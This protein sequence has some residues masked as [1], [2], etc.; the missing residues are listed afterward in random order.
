MLI[1]ASVLGLIFEKIN[2]YKD[3]SFYTPSFITMYMC[4]QTL[5]RAI[6]QKF[7]DA[8]R[9][10]QK[11]DFEKF[12]EFENFEAL[13]QFL[14]EDRSKETRL[15]N[16][17]IFDSIKIC[18]PAVGSGHFLVSALNELIAIK[19]DLRILADSEGNR[20]SVYTKIENDELVILENEE[21][22][23][24]YQVGNKY[25]QNIQKTIFHEKQK[26]IENCLFGVDI[27]SNSV[28]I[29]QLR[30]WI[31]L[32]KNAYYMDETNYQDLETFPNID[33]NIKVGDSLISKFNVDDKMNLFGNRLR[34][35]VK[36]R[37]PDFKKQTELYKSV[38]DRKAKYQIEKKLKE[39]RTWF[40]SLR[41]PEDK[42]YIEL[43]TLE[44]NFTTYGLS[45]FAEQTILDKML[46]DVKA[47]QKKYDKK[48]EIYDN[49]FEWRFEF[50]EVLDDAGNFVGFDAIIGN[51]PY[52]DIKALDKKTVIYL[53]ENYKTASNRIN[54]YSFFIERSLEIMTKNGTS[55]LI[56]PNS[57]LVNSSYSKIR[58]LI[59]DDL[60]LP[61]K[62]PDGVFEEA[63]VE[64]IIYSLQK[65]TNS[66]NCTLIKYQREEVL[67][68]INHSTRSTH[69]S[70]EQKNKAFWKQDENKRFNIYLSN[71]LQSI[72]SKLEKQN[73]K[74]A[75]MCDFSLGIT[76]YDKYKGH[77][78]EQ[79]QK[80]VF[81]STKKASKNYKPLIAGKNIQP[82]F[83]DEKT[84]E[85]IKY[86]DWLGAKR[87]ERF[88]TEDRVLVRQ[89]AS[90]K[91][92][93]IFAS[94][95]EKPL[96]FTQIA[97]ALICK[98][99]KYNSKIITAL[100]NSKLLNTIH[101]Y[102]YLD[103]EKEV[104]QKVLIANCKLLPIPEN[105][106][107][108]II[109]QLEQKVEQILAIKKENQTVSTTE[110]EN[111]ID[112]LVYSLYG[113]D[114]KEINVIEGGLI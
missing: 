103:I 33:I 53:F 80:K 76:P 78:E 34:D 84:S 112:K 19:E 35:L 114:E 42:E 69:S 81:H 97:F 2:G 90:S 45:P 58:E 36:K 72:F 47:A 29:C 28:K 61:I 3:G 92:P 71:D 52:I 104:F 41:S 13:Q 38:R 113:L 89:I 64:T 88:F 51:P 60:L 24:E 9:I 15:K 74:L 110:L 17:A 99:E 22:I 101:R 68:E 4:R 56:V 105:P 96:Y 12:R 6:V 102:L 91:P 25:S 67:E 85:Y 18:D 62:L 27:N 83:I 40:D 108:E 7:S 31:E 59:I 49:S 109:L 57:L 63:S 50:P 75:D 95:T 111:E 46:E 98:T 106:N 32:L 8:Y 82:Y 5:R 1:S 93:R 14:F 87:E 21:T 39:H 79:I 16:N 66:D 94:C 10:E 73:S 26:L 44:N 30:L 54:L 48:M 107:Q 37:I 23:F 86:G 20:L 65:N 55:S 43:K 100:L 77:T 70:V 11:N